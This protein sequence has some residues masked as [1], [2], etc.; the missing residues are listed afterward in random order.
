VRRK[1]RK[2]RCQEPNRNRVP[3]TFSFL[4]RERHD[5]PKKKV[6]KARCAENKELP[7]WKYRP[8]AVNSQCEYFHS[9]SGYSRALASCLGVAGEMP[10]PVFGEGLKK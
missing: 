9:R 8:Y 5:R 6:A 2:K 7:R 10:L 3:D 1:K 4:G